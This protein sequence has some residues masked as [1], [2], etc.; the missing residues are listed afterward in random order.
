LA[1]CNEEV[2]LAPLVQ[3]DEELEDYEAS[4]ER[5]NMEI[6]VVLLSLD[7]SVVL[8]EDLAHLEFG[9]HDVVF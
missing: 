9:P 5:N 1:P 2:P 3:E 4:P 6:N 8:E 7:Y